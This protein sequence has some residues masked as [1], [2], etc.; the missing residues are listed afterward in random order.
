MN[1]VNVSGLEPQALQSVIH[2]EMLQLAMG[3]HTNNIALW[4][5][6]LIF[7]PMFQV[8]RVRLNGYGHGVW[9]G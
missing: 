9:G 4:E 3:G 6:D 2:G 1:H 5:P 8:N 7:R